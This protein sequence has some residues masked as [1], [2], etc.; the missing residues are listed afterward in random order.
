[1][2]GLHGNQVGKACMKYLAR[3]TDQDIEHIAN[4]MRPED[5]EECQA[6]GF[7]PLTALRTSVS[8]SSVCY[9]ARGIDGS[10][11]ALLGAGHGV[12]NGWGTIWLLGT[13][14]IE[15]N[16]VTFL[17][18][19]KEYLSYI[20]D[21]TGFDVLYNYTY[22]KNTLHHRWLKWLGF[23]FIRK[24]ILPSTGSEFIE[25]ARLRG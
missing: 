25:F 22:S 18:H 19:S 13:N 8:H 2:A 10:P 20:Y 5:V 16:T 17:R 23:N 12:Y 14:G 3:P 1:M 7:D 11:I 9:T 6:S 4:N 15:K 24:V 21:E